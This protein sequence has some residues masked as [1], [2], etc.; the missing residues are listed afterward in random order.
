MTKATM[1]KDDS[2]KQKIEDL[3]F[4]LKPEQLE[5]FLNI[6]D[7]Y[8]RIFHNVEKLNSELTRKNSELIMKIESLEDQLKRYKN[9]LERPIEKREFCRNCQIYKHHRN[10]LKLETE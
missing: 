5:S 3:E 7:R 8:G 10:S 9:D 1:K 6:I 4:S 2:G